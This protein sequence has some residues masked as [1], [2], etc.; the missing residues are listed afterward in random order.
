MGTRL[1]VAFRG[2][3]AC[4]QSSPVG[5]YGMEFSG[6]LSLRS[7]HQCRNSGHFLLELEWSKVLQLTQT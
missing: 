4:V 2:R 3:A 7:E 5:K 6:V 1:P